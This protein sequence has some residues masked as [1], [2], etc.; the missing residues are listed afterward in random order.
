MILKV[1]FSILELMLKSEIQLPKYED[2]IKAGMHFGR[3]KSIFH[4]RMKPF[5]YANKEN[6]CIL[7]LVKTCDAILTAIDFMRK[8]KEE[9]KIILF[10][11]TTKQSAEAVKSTAEALGMPYVVNRWLG[12]MLTNFKTIISRVK[13]LEDLEKRK[14]TGG[15]DK[16]TKKE[17]LLKNKEIIALQQRFN[18]LRKLVKIPDVVFVSSLNENQIAVREANKMGVKVVGVVNT[19]SNPDQLD[20]PIPANDNSRKSIEL[21]LETIKNSLL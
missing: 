15:F 16:Y 12:G 19:D 5:V 18:G 17:Q 6:I 1:N 20:Y 7:D 4:P 8:I 3:K 10:V 13:Y 21:I 9:G 2:M 14:E 11:G